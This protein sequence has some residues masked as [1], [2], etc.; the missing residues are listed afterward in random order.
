MNDQA[1]QPYLRNEI[2]FA[3]AMTTS[4]QVM[5]EFMIRQ[6]RNEDLK[7]FVGMSKIIP[8]KT[9]PELPFHVVVPAF[10]ISEF[11]TAFEIGC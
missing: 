7:L 4:S 10:I 8:P 11:R 2:A 5:K 9:V 6:T 1:I 3:D